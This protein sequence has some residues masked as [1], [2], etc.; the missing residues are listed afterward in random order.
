MGY[1]YPKSG[2]LFIPEIRYIELVKN[3]GKYMKMDRN[4]IW[5]YLPGYS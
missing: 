3:P 4:A 1:L 5:A 2:K